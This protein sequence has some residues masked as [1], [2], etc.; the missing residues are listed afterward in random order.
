MIVIHRFSHHSP[1]CSYLPDEQSTMEYELTPHISAEEYEER[2]NAGW[3]K[4]GMILF[5]PACASCQACRPVRILA[6]RFQ[7]DRSQARAWKRNADLRVA[8]APPTVD[9]SR[10]ALYR[11]Y[12]AAQT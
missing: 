2:M 4:F 3:R 11:Q 7:P 6:D 12:H 10:L 9:D 5:H 8:I 1:S